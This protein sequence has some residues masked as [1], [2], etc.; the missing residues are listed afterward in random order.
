MICILVITFSTYLTL[1]QINRSRFSHY[2]ENIT[3]LTTY[4]IS[5]GINRQQPQNQTKWLE[6]VS[7]LIGSDIQIIEGSNKKTGFY[8]LAHGKYQVI[9]SLDITLTAQF[10][11]TIN[12]LTDKWISTTAFLALNEVGHY[13]IEQRESILSNLKQHASFDINRV[14]KNALTLTSKQIRQ[15][16]RGETLLVTQAHLGQQKSITVYA[17]WGNTNDVL[18]IGPIPF[19]NTY[20][21][22]IFF[23]ALFINLLLIAV[24]VYFF[25]NHLRKRVVL[26]QR[27]VDRI[28]ATH[29]LTQGDIYFDDA[30][31]ELNYKINN[32]A[33][34]I[35]SLLEEQAYMIRAI[36][37]D[38]RTPIARLHFR[39]ARIAL[40]VGEEN[41]IIEQCK[42]DL[43]NLNTLI[44]DL[45]SYE[46]LSTRPDIDFVQ[47][48]IQSLLQIEI[49]EINA[50]FPHLQ[51]NFIPS[52]TFTPNV[53]GNKILLVRLFNNILIN[54]GKFASSSV[55]ASLEIIDESV[56][57]QI[58]DDGD[59][60]DLTAINDVFQPFYKADTARSHANSGYGLGL[61]IAQQIVEQ[62]KGTINAK[63]DTNGG[64]LIQIKF[65]LILELTSVEMP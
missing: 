59:G 22:Y 49:N 65:P 1:E 53:I 15:I 63:N 42:T 48:D 62:H 61:A 60:F 38:L 25:I 40:L 3:S 23:S 55:H 39:L 11:Y 24:V 18:R 33:N 14:S 57:I 41:Q 52:D 10:S 56:L 12:D 4:L 64:A 32:M 16:N 50:L 46:R 43:T 44:D 34:R 51:F 36:S 2:L 5:Q 31:N 6:L 54:A 17:P 28:G 13:P 20:P 21:S 37:H 26:I 7:S 27:T 9:S 19:F 35:E 58:N 29:N 47:L 45:L 30:I 8:V